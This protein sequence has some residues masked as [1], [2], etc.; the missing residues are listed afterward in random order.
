MTVVLTPH[1]RGYLLVEYLIY[2]ALFVVVIG[3]AFGAFYRFLDHSRD[4][5][6]NG[7]DILRVLRVG[8][9]WRADIREASATPE[10][11]SEQGLSACEI[12]KTNS[13]VAYIFSEGAV[14]RQVADG[15]PRQVLPRVRACS[16]VQDQRD[17]VSS[18]RWELEL[19]T[20]KKVVRIR[21]LFTFE[22]VPPKLASEPSTP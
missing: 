11:R 10:L 3:V 8:E 19:Q 9:L 12:P 18:W 16:M 17:G 13:R 14:W 15:L 22:A 1:R 6:R 20:R 5:A 21:P 4:L 2:M 7:E